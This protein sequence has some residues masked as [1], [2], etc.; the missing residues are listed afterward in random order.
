MKPPGSKPQ[1]VGPASSLSRARAARARVALPTS[2]QPKVP[3]VPKSASRQTEAE[4]HDLQRLMAKAV[5]RPLTSRDTMQ[6]TWSDGRP[7][8]RVAESFIKPNDRLT[9]FE[10]LEIYNRQYW[11]RV[12]ASFYE[13]YPGLRA[14]LGDRKFEQL[15]DAYLTH[16]PSQSYTLRNLGSRLVK[17]LAAQSPRTLP[18]KSLALDL[19][20]LEWAHI[21]AFDNP[22]RSSLELDTL[23]GLE[24]AQIT[25]QLQPHLTLLRLRHEV[26]DFLI[27]L[28]SGAGLRQE[29][30]NAMEQHQKQFKRRLARVL[31]PHV[32]YLAVHRH[33]NAIYYKRLDIVQ[34]RLLTALQS[35]AT[36]EAACG[37]L[38]G[39]KLPAN[40]GQSIQE[41]FQTWARLG[42]FCDL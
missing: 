16:Y 27:E 10:R 23:L 20:R 6:K 32:N 22:A 39:L 28:K 31:R 42:W 34:Y 29:A 21:E 15:A 19:A 40:L 36:L 11:L 1:K 26:D 7:T 41:W 12:R 33:Q 17:Y 30:S 18:H 35:G 25:F 38:V 4:Y 5:M 2:A 9:S 37:Q 13:D 3:A 14:V 24:P 8:R